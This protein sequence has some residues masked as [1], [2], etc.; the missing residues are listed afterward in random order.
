MLQIGKYVLLTK[1]EIKELNEILKGHKDEIDKANDHCNA[2]QTMLAAKINGII[3][4]IMPTLPLKKRKAIER[5]LTPRP[6]AGTVK[7]TVQGF[8]RGK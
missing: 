6:V 5:F 3:D 1:E 2:L 7:D 8:A 4:I